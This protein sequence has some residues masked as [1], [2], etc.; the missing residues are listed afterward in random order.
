MLR[1]SKAEFDSYRNMVPMACP[2]DGELL[3]NAPTTDAGS[4]VERFCKYDGWAYP[5]DWTPP[6]RP[7]VP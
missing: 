4:G 2:N 5:R 3:I 6:D 1:H 7:G